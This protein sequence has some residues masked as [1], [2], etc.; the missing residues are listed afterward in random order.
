L[1]V[2]VSFCVTPKIDINGSIWATYFP[3]V[4][5]AQPLVRNFDL[6]AI[7]NLLSEDAEFVPD[8]IADCRNL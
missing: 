2:V 5:Q 8:A 4:A 7:L 6:P 3:G 1:I